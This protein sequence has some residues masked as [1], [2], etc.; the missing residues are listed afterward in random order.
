MVVQKPREIAALVLKRHSAGTGHVETLLSKALEQ[1]SLSSRDRSLCQELVYGVIRWQATL[2]WLVSRKA[3]SC[4]QKPMLR[5]L[6]R[7]G[8]YQLFWLDRI[9][10][11][12]AVH[13][14]VEL[15]K[16]YG[17]GHQSGFINAV[18]RGYVLE[19]DATK[20]ALADLKI[21]H[22]HLGYS[23]PEWL[24]AKW[25]AR[26][27]KDNTACLMEWNNT[28]APTYARVNTLK[29]NPTELLARWRSEMVEY[30]FF[31]ADWLP[32]NLVFKLKSYPP[33]AQLPSFQQGLFYVQ[34]PSTLLAVH[35]LDPHRGETILDCCAAPGGKTTCIAQLMQNRGLIT[36]EDISEER[37]R[38]LR[39]NCR[40]LGVAC[41]KTVLIP[42]NRPSTSK[43]SLTAEKD[44]FNELQA[45]LQQH[46]EHAPEDVAG[47]IPAKQAAAKDKGETGSRGSSVPA[48]QTLPGPATKDRYDKILV[49][50]P[51]SNTGVMRRRVDLRWRINSEELKRLQA[52]QIG[53][54]RRAATQ[55][56]PGGVLVYCTCSLETEENQQV[57]SRFVAEYPEFTLERERE[58][59]PFVDRVDGS[60]VAKLRRQ[61]A[62]G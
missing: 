57:I 21:T 11:H 42:T 30:D 50:S 8:L 16:R 59:V 54:L 15:A 56:K 37:I 53:L 38:L 60:Y 43:L 1:A 12:A 40:R 55:L 58:L 29:T 3:K 51:C 52:V 26:W 28:P 5:T 41:V 61:P 27:G 17:F 31:C 2:D 33:L 7:L 62:K 6:L 20:R 39:E 10:A 14:T 22:P 18:L 45:H 24:W 36:A 32:E 23:H 4:T 9:P 34:D 13:E 48:E 35:E 19:F 44:F 49:D 46:Y 47:S 25:Q